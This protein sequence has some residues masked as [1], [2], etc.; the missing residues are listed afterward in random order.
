[1]LF[2]YR[3]LIRRR[4][5]AEFIVKAI[6]AFFVTIGMILIV[7]FLILIFPIMILDH[8]MSGNR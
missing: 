7:I 1:M 6:D 4:K 8:Y 3:R 2:A 5:I